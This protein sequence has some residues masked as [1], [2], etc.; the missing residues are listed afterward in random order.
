MQRRK[1][2]NTAGAGMAGILAA[3]VAPAFAQGAMPEIK[4]R[5]ASSFPKSLDT[6]Y[7]AAEVMS[8][9]V[10]AAT[11]GK[12]QIQVFAAGEIVPAFGVVDAVQNGTIQAAHTAPYYF[13]G[14]EPTFALDT[15][16]PF[17]LNARQTNAWQIFGGG[18]ELFA[19]FYKGYNMHRVPCGNTGAQMG[20][21]F[22][23]EIKSVADLKGLKMRIGGMAGKVLE[24]LGVVPQL[25]PG[26]DIYPALEK[27]TIDAAEWVGPYD[28]EKLGFVK[29]APYYYYPGWWEGSANG[30]LFISTS[31]WAELPK[32]YQQMVRIA[33]AQVAADLISKYD[34]GNAPA[35]KRL[36]VAGA[37]LRPFSLEIMDAAY[38]A[39]NELFT[40]VAGKN[41][42]FKKLYDSMVAFRNEQY[43]WHQVCEAT[44]DNYMIRQRNRA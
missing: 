17:S 36:V 39:T 35:I 27:G 25:I 9:R 23:K 12:F 20:G 18:I 42:M 2:I 24:K 43:Q 33:A 41:P 5:M 29:I 26:G 31:K 40:E 37:Q 1:F 7:G 6:I 44:Y 8:K 32:L 38:T 3:G 34:V 4:W 13:W 30:H 15:A 14:K 22:R 21:W 10:A 28:D 19:E 16:I 11:G